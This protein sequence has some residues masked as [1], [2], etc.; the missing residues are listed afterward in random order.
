MLINKSKLKE[1]FSSK[2]F[3]KW[4][5]AKDSQKQSD[6]KNILKSN[7]NDHLLEAQL[8]NIYNY[9]A[10]SSIRDEFKQFIID[11]F[12]HIITNED[13][14]DMPLHADMIIDH[15]ANNIFTN[16]DPSLLR[17]PMQ[18]I[19]SNSDQQKLKLAIKSFTS[20]LDNIYEAMIVGNNAYIEYVPNNH[21]DIVNK[22]PADSWEIRKYKNK[23]A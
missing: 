20:N 19:L 8:I 7:L 6:L 1:L 16:Y 13:E 2:S 10:S 4:L 14:I 11:N 17:F 12:N 9:L 5:K 23:G 21:S 3:N 22:I 18:I 15:D